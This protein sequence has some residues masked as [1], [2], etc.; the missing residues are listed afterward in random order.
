MAD[1]K[2]SPAVENEIAIIRRALQG[3][4]N[5]SVGGGFQS[6][7]EVPIVKG[8]SFDKL[9]EADKALVTKHL[10]EEL[11]KQRPTLDTRYS[12]ADDLHNGV[13]V[14]TTMYREVY[15][16]PEALAELKHPKSKAAPV[17]QRP[18]ESPTR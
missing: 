6:S 14:A 8:S 15:S 9:S 17:P 18:A 13:I 3:V 10:D 5:N 1:Q 11:R 12:S 7:G 16:S 4:A 2:V